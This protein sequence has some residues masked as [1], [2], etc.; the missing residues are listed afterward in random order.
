MLATS[1]KDH[2]KNASEKNCHQNKE[3]SRIV[4]EDLQSTSIVPE[5]CDYVEAIYSSKPYVGQ[6]EEIDGEGE[7]VHINFFEHKGDLQR[8]SKFHKPIKEDKIWIPLSDI[9]YIVTEPT[10]TKFEFVPIYTYCY[11]RYLERFNF[12]GF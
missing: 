3:P 8:R 7:E 10:A 11:A 5:P 9:I 12:Y 2:R 1:T 4:T 6:F